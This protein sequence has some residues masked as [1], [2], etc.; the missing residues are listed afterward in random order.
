M[1]ELGQNKNLNFSGFTLIEL[2][3]VVAIIGFLLMIAFPRYS[4]SAQIAAETVCLAN[5]LQIIK[6]LNYSSQNSSECFTLE[7]LV[8]SGYFF[9]VPACPQGGTYSLQ[10]IDTES[11]SLF[12]VFCSIHPSDSTN[13]TPTPTP[14]TPLGST[15]SDIS[16]G[17]I[18]RLEGY[19]AQYHSYARSWGSY[20]FADIGLVAGDWQ[21]SVE[22]IIYTPRGNRLQIKPEN[23]YSFVVRKISEEDV[24]M[25][26]DTNWVFIYSLFDQKWYYH[27]INPM[28]EIDISTLQVKK[29]S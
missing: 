20:A 25:S 1:D 21:N 14:L 7:C 9:A 3:I 11:G 28:N 10:K 24:T 12:E 6:T 18:I 22:H 16:G 17:F 5:R 26:S 13:S 2:V 4:R 8:Q 29:N 15:F 27:E 19:Y 23:G